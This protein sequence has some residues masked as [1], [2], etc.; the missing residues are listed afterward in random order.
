[1]SDIKKRPKRKWLK[2]SLLTLV[3]LLVIGVGYFI[4]WGLTPLGPSDDALAALENTEQVTVTKVD[5]TWVFTPATTTPTTGYIFY[6]GGHVDARNY[7]IYASEIAA[8]GYLVVIP[9]MPL[10]LAVLNINAADALMQEYPDIKTWGIGGHSL[11]GAMAATYAAAH[12]DKLAGLV[13]LAAYPASGSDLS[14]SGL[15]VLSM[16][17]TL[18]TVVNR[19]KLEAGRQLLPNDTVYQVLNGGNHAQFGS[20]GLQPGDTENPTMSAAE[21]RTTAVYYTVELLKQL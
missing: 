19:T 14:K 4:W 21:Q 6:P 10:S 7:A 9:E 17:G 5:N 13:L 12:P 16:Y 3:A 20:Y 11:G 15:H 8:Q 1:M 2:Y 18:D